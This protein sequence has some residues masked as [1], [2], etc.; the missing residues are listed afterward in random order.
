MKLR[1]VNERKEQAHNTASLLWPLAGAHNCFVTKATPFYGIN[2]KCHKGTGNLCNLFNWL[3]QVHFT[4]MSTFDS[5]EV[6]THT[7]AHHKQTH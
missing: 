6:G 4:C 3:I 7:A 2:G 1:R 5:L